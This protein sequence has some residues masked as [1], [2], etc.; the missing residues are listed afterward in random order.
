MAKGLVYVLL[1]SLAVL[2]ALGIGGRTA[3]PTEALAAVR[4]GTPGV[5]LLWATAVGLAAYAL[6]AAFSAIVDAENLGSDA[7][8][9][10]RRVAT[11]VAAIAYGGLAVSAFHL[12]TSSGGG[13]AGGGGAQSATETLLRQPAG[14][15]LVG[16]VA[17]VITLYALFQLRTAVTAE[18]MRRLSLEGAMSGH[19]DLVKRIGQIGLSARAIAFL[20]VAGF[21]VWAALDANA[22]RARGLE[23]S[24]STLREQPYGTWLLLA[25]AAGLVAYGV[26]QMIRGRYM[27]VH[28]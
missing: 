28:A 6:W 21:L 7:A 13:G 1:G 5:A 26:H 15:W 14:A 9:I 17:G 27:N 12:A 24:L 19:R 8:G 20:L 18:F 10:A 22:R 4:Q 16:I 25:L 11:G 3:S 23:G 2:E